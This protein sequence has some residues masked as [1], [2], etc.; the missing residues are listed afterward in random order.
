MNII[1][2]KKNYKID[3]LLINN[4]KNKSNNENENKNNENK[5]KSDKVI[6][7]CNRSS[8]PYELLAYY[9]KWIE[10]YISYGINVALRNYRGYGESNGFCNIENIQSDSEEIVKYLKNEL[11]FQNI[12]VHDIGFGGIC[13]GYLVNKNLVNFCFV[14]R[15]FGNLHEFV[16]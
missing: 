14:D 7:I 11:N 6:L 16:N 5:N 13:A 3:C 10:C 9:D 2:N 4:Q 12:V 15:C 1:I 8:F